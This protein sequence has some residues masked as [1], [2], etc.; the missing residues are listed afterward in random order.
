MR[1][2]SIITVFL[3]IIAA[4]TLVSAQQGAY[5]SP[6]T[7]AT[8]TGTSPI[9]VTGTAISCPTCGTSSG[10]VTSVSGTNNQI[11][12]ATG[13]TT[14]VLSLSSTL[15]FPGTLSNATAVAA[16][17][18]VF[19]LTPAVTTGLTGTTNRPLFYRDAT[20]NTEPST[21][22]TGDIYIGHNAAASNCSSFLEQH[23]NGGGINFRVDCSGGTT[24]T[25]ITNTGGTSSSKYS[26]ATNCS[27]AGTAASPSVVSCST[28][29]AG[30]FSCA[31]NA[32]GGTCTVN[33]TA[34]ATNSDIIITPTA[35]AG[36]RLSVT[37]NTTADIP[38]GP[39]VASIVNGT[40]FTINLGT[41]AT[42]PT[43]YFFT[44]VN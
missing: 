27:A 17:T 10:T 29:S 9:V 15:A 30:A 4:A 16:S 6:A 28:A 36:T 40:S 33:T 8:Y 42:N 35:S 12:V 3:L 13:T 22:S 26:T 39:R 23:S 38:T 34:A 37:C 19:V 5:Q 25:S 24:V 20:G 31:T 21:W 32:S 2:L 14:P 1:K 11:N 41:V 7:G 44:I 43:C 18:P